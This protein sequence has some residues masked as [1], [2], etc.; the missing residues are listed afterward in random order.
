[1]R[2]TIKCSSDVSLWCQIT[3][4]TNPLCASIFFAQKSLNSESTSP[5]VSW[6]F[7]PVERCLW[8][9]IELTNQVTLGTLCV[10]W[11]TVTSNATLPV[12]SDNSQ[13]EMHRTRKS[14]YASSPGRGTA[15]QL[16]PGPIPFYVYCLSNWV[17]LAASQTELPL[18][19]TVRLLLTCP[20]TEAQK[21]QS[22]SVLCV[23]TIHRMVFVCWSL[24]PTHTHIKTVFDRCQRVWIS[25]F[26][27]RAA[28]LGG[29]SLPL[30]HGKSQGGRQRVWRRR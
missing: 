4:L 9:V 28:S 21:Q 1:M 27:S 11:R 24:W 29:L 16:K 22:V 5:V 2:Q 26:V 14:A 17:W 23:P 18:T 13:C 19:F 6:W 20:S 7:P 3:L 15:R 30:S 8:E 10:P 12:C 25:T